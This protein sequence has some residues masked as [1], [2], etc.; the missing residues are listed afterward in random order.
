MNKRILVFGA[1]LTFACGEEETMPKIE[2]AA[3]ADCD[4]GKLCY[5]SK[6][7]VQERYNCLEGGDEKPM[8]TVSPKSIDF[9]ETS[10][11][12]KTVSISIE[13][14]GTCT[15]SIVDASIDAFDMSRFGCQ[16]CNDAVLPISIYPNRTSTFDV[17]MY[18]GAPGDY[19]GGLV[20]KSND[21]EASTIRLPLLGSSTGKPK[22]TVLPEEIDFG[23][24]RA[25]GEVEKQVFIINEGSGTTSL[26]VEK[27]E[28]VQDSEMPFSLSAGLV[29]PAKISPVRTDPHAG[30]VIKVKYRPNAPADHRGELLITY[31]GGQVRRVK[32]KGS[33][34]PPNINATP[35]TIDFGTVQ[36]GQIGFQRITVQNYLGKNPLRAHARLVDGTS[37]DLRL[38]EQ[39]PPAIPP[40][41]LFELKV[42]YEPTIAGPINDSLVIESNDPDEPALNI[43][44]TGNG[45]A[46]GEEIIAVDMSFVADS[47]S[48]L[49]IDL[50]DVDL[51]LENPSGQV[52]REA[53][54]VTRW[55][56]KGNCTWSAIPP[57]ENPERFVLSQVTEDGTYKIKLNYIEDCATLPTALAASLLG[58]GTEALVSELTEGQTMVN[59]EEVAN[60]IEEVC[61]ERRNTTASIT[62]R[63][64][65]QI[66]AEQSFRV[67]AK[68]A[69]IDAFTLTRN[70]GRFSI[71][72]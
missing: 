20:I 10:S 13:N 48:L 64:N 39:F 19:E 8:I 44:V 65:G 47:N 25:G 41:G 53:M 46:V 21:S 38:P 29:F 6:C 7:Q 43:P 17:H 63:K 68:G 18:P 11:S 16:I 40:G 12:T 35:L 28:L 70:N 49:D 61:A 2:C 52:C 59:R 14:S 24:M 54:P 23:F 37:Q 15:L 66:I 22:I 51:I 56:S 5:E 33:E 31:D 34:L 27:A 55:G 3:D 32:L 60:V 58:L 30:I 71:T 26:V 62:V 9:G 57:R 50:R 45:D 67:E 36:L 69:L 72:P 1:L 4:F 42:I